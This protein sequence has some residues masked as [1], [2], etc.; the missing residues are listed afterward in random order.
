MHT[1]PLRGCSARPQCHPSLLWPQP[2]GSQARP[3]VPC[4]GRILCAVRTGCPRLLGF[5]GLVVFERVLWAGSLRSGAAAVPSVIV[6]APSDAV[7]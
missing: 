5:C 6:I 2:L 4:P 3:S 7:V 1:E